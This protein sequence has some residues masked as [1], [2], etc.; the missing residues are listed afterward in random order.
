MYPSKSSFSFRKPPVLLANMAVFSAI[1][2]KKTR[3][4]REGIEELA[5]KCGHATEDD[6]PVQFIDVGIHYDVRNEWNF[7]M[8]ILPIIWF[9]LIKLL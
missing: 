9:L 3:K 2:N 5:N 1:K 4:L 8:F 6:A 7:D